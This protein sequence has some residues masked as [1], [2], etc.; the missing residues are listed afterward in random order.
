MDVPPENES[1]QS[2]PVVIDTDE[3]E[4]FIAERLKVSNDIIAKVLGGEDA[5]M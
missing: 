3:M 4:R 2:E 1:E 5:F